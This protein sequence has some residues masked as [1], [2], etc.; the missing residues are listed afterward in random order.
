M[1]CSSG[2][3]APGTHATYGECLKAKNLRHAVSVPGN[4]HDRAKQKSWDSELDLYRTARAQGVQPSGTS[5]AQVENALKISNETGMAY[6][7]G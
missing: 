7:A 2:C 1:A 6:Q 5:R 3:L 4:N